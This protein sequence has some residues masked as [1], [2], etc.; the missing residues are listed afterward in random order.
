LGA[1]RYI[2]KYAAI[3]AKRDFAFRASV[4]VVE[5]RFGQSLTRDSTKILYADHSG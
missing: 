3:L 1:K 2:L 4:Q 5:Y